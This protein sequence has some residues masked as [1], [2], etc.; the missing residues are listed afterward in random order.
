[1]I[2]TE[3]CVEFIFDNVGAIE[4]EKLAEIKDGVVMASV[5]KKLF[6]EAKRDNWMTKLFGKKADFK[7]R[8]DFGSVEDYKCYVTTRI[9]PNM[10][11]SSNMY[12]NW[13][14]QTTHNN[15]SYGLHEGQVGCSQ[16]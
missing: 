12:S 10:F 7:K 13:N 15:L 4:D 11:V 16:D 6:K 5:V 3:K 2:L 9:K 14:V 8:E 1:M